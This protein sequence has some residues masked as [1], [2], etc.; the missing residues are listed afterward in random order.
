M[1]NFNNTITSTSAT[2]ICFTFILKIKENR[3]T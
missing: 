2:T 3:N 1:A